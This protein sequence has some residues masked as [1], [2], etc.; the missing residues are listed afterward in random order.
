MSAG[1]P[2]APRQRPGPEPRLGWLAQDVEQE[3]PEL[4]LLSCGVQVRRPESLTGPCPRDV[5][6][7]LH[8]LSN[9]FRGARA[10]G[11]RREPV[12]AAY[13]V[14]FRQIGLDPDV[15]RTPIEEAARER[16][17][18]G[19]FLP[20]E[21]LED[22]LLIALLDTGIPVWALATETVDGPLG[23][24]SSAEGERLGRSE[25]APALPAGRLVVADGSTPLAV[26]FGEL[27][28]GHRPLAGT[29]ELTLFAI[30]VAGVPGLYAEEALWA[31][32]TALEQP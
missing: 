15:V 27:A 5:R 23:I 4:R 21:L 8:G 30:A 16:M 13:R 18:R 26:L 19:G 31:C 14:F 28:P 32:Q 9:Q 6:A 1:P 22:V 11:I 25:D 24:R 2:G 29:R 7:R 20:G 12:P 10:I 3:L 17:L